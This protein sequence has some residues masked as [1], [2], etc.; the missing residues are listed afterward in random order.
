MAS[1]TSKK[2]SPET[3]DAAKDQQLPP[4]SDRDFKAYNRMAERMDMFVSH[5]V[6]P[7]SHTS[8]AHTLSSTSTSAKPGTS[9]G[10]PAPPAA[11]P[12][13]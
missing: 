4:L 3:K 13:E 6:S 11:A 1:D 10:Q 9:S 5:P 2:P 8:L 12:K 7:Q